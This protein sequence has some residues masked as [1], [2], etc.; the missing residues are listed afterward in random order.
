MKKRK[1]AFDVKK[2]V[3]SWLFALSLLMTIF[4]VTAFATAGESAEPDDSPPRK[5]PF[6]STSSMAQMIK[7]D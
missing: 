7:T 3:M 2:K 1:R 5:P 4:P 6:I